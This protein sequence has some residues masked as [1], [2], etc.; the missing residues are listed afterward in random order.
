MAGT[1]HVVAACQPDVATAPVVPS[2]PEAI[3][4][5]YV[6]GS[7]SGSEMVGAVRVGV[8]V[9][10]TEPSTGAE[11]ACAVIAGVLV[12]KLHVEEMPSVEVPRTPSYPSLT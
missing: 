11:P 8:V 7:P 12:V 4:K 9:V 6:T 1:V 10:I 2:A 5:R 3:W